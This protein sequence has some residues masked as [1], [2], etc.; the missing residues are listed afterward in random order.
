MSGCAQSRAFLLGALAQIVLVASEVGLLVDSFDL[1]GVH[2]SVYRDAVKN[3]P[4]YFN[5]RTQ[6]AQWEDPRV[7]VVSDSSR[8]LVTVVFLLPFFVIGLGGFAYIMYLKYVQPE[9]LK[10]PKKNKKAVASSSAKKPTAVSTE[11]KLEGK[12]L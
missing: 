7:R 1:E 8:L 6:K 4:Y 5:S 10:P 9:K 2:W 3:R 12:K 11:S